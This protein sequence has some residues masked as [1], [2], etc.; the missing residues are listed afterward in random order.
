MRGATLLERPAVSRGPEVEGGLVSE[1][2]IINRV[3]TE[4]G[5]E[6]TREA[7]NRDLQEGALTM[8]S[9]DLCPSQG[10]RAAHGFTRMFRA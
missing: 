9:E 3:A 2:A 1:P 7:G 10:I 8:Q 4:V 6:L 5:D